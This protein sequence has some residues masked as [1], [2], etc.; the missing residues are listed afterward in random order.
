MDDKDKIVSPPPMMFPRQKLE[1]IWT[2]FLQTAKP[3]ADAE[4]F[5]QYLLQLPGKRIVP[6]T[7]QENLVLMAKRGRD[8]RSAQT[9]YWAALRK[10]TFS[11]TAV[12]DLLF[13]SKNHE[14][15]FDDAVKKILGDKTN[16]EA[17]QQSIF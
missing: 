11:Q 16:P 12:T 13:T 10:G 3:Y 8:M 4:A 17:T 5:Y 14:Q 1:E 6:L 2:A 7:E 9:T 15:R